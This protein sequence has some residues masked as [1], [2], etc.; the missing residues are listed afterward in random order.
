MQ[1]TQQ[2]KINIKMWKTGETMTII[3]INIDISRVVGGKD[4]LV[5]KR[6]L[7]Q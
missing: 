6:V 2:D 3:S 7:V 5:D 4:V 1:E